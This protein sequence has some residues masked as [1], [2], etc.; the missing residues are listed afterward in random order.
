MTYATAV[1]MPDPL[2]HCS[3]L[4]IEP[5]PLQQPK[6]LSLDPKPTAPQQEF[7]AKGFTFYSEP[8]GQLPGD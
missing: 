4:E 6:P 5:E 3:G 7:N 8:S 2:T 1:A